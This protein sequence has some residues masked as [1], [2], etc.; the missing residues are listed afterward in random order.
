MA[1][2]GEERGAEAAH[3]PTTITSACT[4]ESTLDRHAAASSEL[5]RPTAGIPNPPKRISAYS[6]PA[7][8][9]VPR[10]SCWHA[11]CCSRVSVSS[12]GTAHTASAAGPRSTNRRDAVG[13]GASEFCGFARFDVVAMLQSKL[14]GEP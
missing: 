5:S 6:T 13:E 3:L 2:R 11:G 1:K 8:S 4:V 14:S 10:I 9:V 12:P 7:M